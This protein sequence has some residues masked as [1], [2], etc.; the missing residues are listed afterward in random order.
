MQI[1][2]LMDPIFKYVVQLNL[3]A[4]PIDTHGTKILR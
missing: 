1:G 4:N 3:V 2:S